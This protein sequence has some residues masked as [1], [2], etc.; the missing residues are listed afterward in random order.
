MNLTGLHILLTYICN[1]TCDHCFVWGSPNQRGTWTWKALNNLLQ[2][3]QEV[4]SIKQIYFEGGE[5]FL[6]YPLMLRG[7]KKAV[8]LGYQVGILSNAYWAISVEDAVMWLMPFSDDIHS[9]TI[10]TDRYHN[11]D[12]MEEWAKNAVQAAKHLEI[13]VGTIS[14]AQPED[15]N[16]PSVKGVLPQGLSEV[17]YRGRAAQELVDYAFEKQPWTAYTTCPYEDLRSPSRIH[18][19]PLGFLH[20][21]QGI[22]MGNINQVSLA[23]LCDQYQP[24]DHPIVGPLLTG[25]PAELFRYYNLPIDGKYADACHL[26]DTARRRLRDRFPGELCPDQMYGAS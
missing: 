15:Q 13:P 11:N 5:P 12:E 9:L 26:C 6:Y 1:C 25:G 21:C 16:A 4:P 3:S 18:V 10:S 17:R 7:I 20:I 14:I 23:Q 19:D 2:Q 22:T 24:E 8:S